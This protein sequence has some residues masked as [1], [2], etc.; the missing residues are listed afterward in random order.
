MGLDDKV[1]KSLIASGWFTEAQQEFAEFEEVS[2]RRAV[3]LLGDTQVNCLVADSPELQTQG[4]QGHS[5][6]GPYD[7]MV[8][9]Y[10]EP[11]RVAFH[12]G[13]VE[14]PIDMLFVGSDS[15]VTKIVANIE[16]GERGQWGMPHTVMVIEVNAGFCEAHGI[17][18]GADVGEVDD[19]DLHEA[20]LEARIAQETFPNYPRKD[21]NPAPL[22]KN[23]TPDRFK[24]RDLVDKQVDSLA[25]SP[26]TENTDG[27]D[28][29]VDVFDADGDIG[30]SIRSL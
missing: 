1:A 6:L 8:F 29:T 16:P 30:P 27:G 17:E 3:I 15:R 25:F 20:A 22:I 14:F 11:R 26:L 19:L 23:I 2:Y 5:A 18:V 10:Q 12:M 28:L 13:K 24:D 4:L 7:A 21:I 9:P